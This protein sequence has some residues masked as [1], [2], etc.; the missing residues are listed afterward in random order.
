[1]ISTGKNSE[2]R[3]KIYS[4]FFA[5][6]FLVTKLFPEKKNRLLTAGVLAVGA[7][8]S[9]TTSFTKTLKM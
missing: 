7:E 1:M 5:S 2:N 3:K 8:G 6:K 4:K 9:I